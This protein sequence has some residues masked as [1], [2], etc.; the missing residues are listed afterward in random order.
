MNTTAPQS[1]LA[2]SLEQD[3]LPAQV[4]SIQHETYDM[5]FASYVEHMRMGFAEIRAGSPGSSKRVFLITLN[6]GLNYEAERSRFLQSDIYKFCNA[7]DGL[8]KRMSEVPRG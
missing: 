2:E 5:H 8:R 4:S 6:A 3:L 1:T 7:E